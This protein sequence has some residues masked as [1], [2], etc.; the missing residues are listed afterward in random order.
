MEG[1]GALHVR[2]ACIHKASEAGGPLWGLRH[3]RG[4]K[5]AGS[6]LLGG[7]A[8]RKPFCFALICR[9]EMQILATCPALDCVGSGC[10]LFAGAF[11]LTGSFSRL[12]PRGH[13]R[14]CHCVLWR[15]LLAAKD[16][17]EWLVDV[18]QSMCKLWVPKPQP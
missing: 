18:P 14:P 5:G 3:G 7:G 9:D 10:L 6:A 15:L 16:F 11:S 17:S 13:A 4:A 1:N 8:F 2:E 12:M